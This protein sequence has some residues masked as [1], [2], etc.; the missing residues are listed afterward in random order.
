MSSTHGT[1]TRTDDG[2]TIYYPNDAVRRQQLNDTTLGKQLPDFNAT[3]INPSSKTAQTAPVSNKTV[4]TKPVNPHERPIAPGITIDTHALIG[5]GATV[6]LTIVVYT[7]VL[8]AIF[9]Q[10]GH[11]FVNL[12][13]RLGHHS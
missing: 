11:L 10:F 12:L 1:I 8:F 4:E 6:L 3:Y 7:L 9:K 2:F 5:V 13:G